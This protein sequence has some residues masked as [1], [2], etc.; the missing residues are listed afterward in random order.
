MYMSKRNCNSFTSLQ[1]LIV[2][3][4]NNINGSK[5]KCS[6]YEL[7]LCLYDVQCNNIFE[8]GN[9]KLCNYDPNFAAMILCN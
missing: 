2:S 7:C 3:L 5:K 9:I 8:K 1:K 4:G 6:Q